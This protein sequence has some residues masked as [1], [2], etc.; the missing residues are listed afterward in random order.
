MI[1]AN[2]DTECLNA[3]Q[4][5]VICPKYGTISE[6]KT[7]V[8][9]GT[10]KCSQFSWANYYSDWVCPV[11]AYVLDSLSSRW[12]FVAGRDSASL[13]GDPNPRSS[14]ARCTPAINIAGQ[15]TPLSS[16]FYACLQRNKEIDCSQFSPKSSQKIL[17]SSPVI[18]KSDSLSDTFFAVLYVISW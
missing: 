11:V 17:H 3:K 18:L 14:A 5:A 9:T 8:I 7:K 1:K 16:Q 12:G 15:C 4:I 2:F 13:A 6:S 10:Y